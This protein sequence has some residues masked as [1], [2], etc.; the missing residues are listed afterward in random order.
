MMGRSKWYGRLALILAAFGWVAPVSG[1]AGAPKNVP[2]EARLREAEELKG[3][4]ERLYGEGK[5]GEA[6]TLAARAC[7]ILAA[8]G[9]SPERARGNHASVQPHAA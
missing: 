2:D 4:Y 7:A 1:R 9:E 8:R 6:A 3:E 5:Y